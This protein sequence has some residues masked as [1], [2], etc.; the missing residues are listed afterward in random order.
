MDLEHSRLVKCLECRL[1]GAPPRFDLTPP[2]PLPAT[3]DLFTTTSD[4]LNSLNLPENRQLARQLKNIKLKKC[5]LRAYSTL[6]PSSNNNNLPI[7]TTT[8]ATT[9]SP[10]EVFTSS[11]SLLRLTQEQSLI[12]FWTSFVLFL[13]VLTIAAIFTY[14]LFQIRAQLKHCKALTL[15]NTTTNNS[16]SS[17]SSTKSNTMSSNLILT[18]SSYG[19]TSVNECE[20]QRQNQNNNNS[21]SIFYNQLFESTK[22][23]NCWESSVATSSS[24][25][26]STRSSSSSSS[27]DSSPN[28]R[29]SNSTPHYLQAV[30]NCSN[31]LE[32]HLNRLNL[33]NQ[34]SEYD[35]I[36]SQAYSTCATGGG[37]GGGV[38]NSYQ[39]QQHHQPYIVQPILHSTCQMRPLTLSHHHQQQHQPQHH[40]HE[41]QANMIFYLRP[42]SNLTVNAMVSGE[43]TVC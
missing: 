5:L 38:H 12:I 43:V 2:P 7:T 35:E 15:N 42:T 6:L 13:I 27:T 21:S 18:P 24:I 9:M 41:Q 14:K 32:A 8:T 17:V 40:I 29:R 1:V 20:K 11:S 26:S 16:S 19:K 39:P 33:V 23:M 3:L 10:D 4:L 37:G 30:P 25:A 31:L 36:N 34:V 22:Q 28:K